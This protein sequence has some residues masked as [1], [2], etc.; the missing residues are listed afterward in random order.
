MKPRPASQWSL[1]DPR[2]LPDGQDYAGTGL[3]WEPATLLEAYANGYFPMPRDLDQPPIDW[4][5]PDP[6]AVF[7]PRAIRMS[8]SLRQSMR[9]FRFTL[10]AN[11]AAVVEGCAAPQRDSRWIDDSVRNAYGRLHDLGWAHSVEVWRG[12]ELVGG[13]YGVELGGL[14][15]G[16]SMFHTARDASKA[17]LAALGWLLRDGER[18]IDSQWMTPHLASM[19]AVA[20]SRATY[21]EELPRFLGLAET[22]LDQPREFTPFA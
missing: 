3:D 7:D 15:A 16:E 4:W 19:G 12:D 1:A 21:V 17:A 10:N 6:R 13:L 8:R 22:L 20:I 14:F 11:F 18:R 2:T 9:G 5:S